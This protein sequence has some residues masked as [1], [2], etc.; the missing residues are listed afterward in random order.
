MGAGFL[1]LEIIIFFFVSYWDWNI[2]V[3]NSP[4]VPTTYLPSLSLSAIRF[5]AMSFENCY[6]V[7]VFL[8]G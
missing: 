8:V 5:M 7:G 3:Y 6:I 2:V 1:F 4:W